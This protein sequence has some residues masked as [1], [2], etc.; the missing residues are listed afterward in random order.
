M[1][2]PVT[3]HLLGSMVPLATLSLSVARWCVCCD[4]VTVQCASIYVLKLLWRILTS[5]KHWDTIVDPQRTRPDNTHCAHD[6]CGIQQQQHEQHPHEPLARHHMASVQLAPPCFSSSSHL[7]TYDAA[8]AMD[9]PAWWPEPEKTLYTLSCA[10]AA[11]LPW[12]AT[13]NVLKTSYSNYRK[14]HT[15]KQRSSKVQN[16]SRGHVMHGAWWCLA[17]VDYKHL[18]SHV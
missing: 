1:W 5:P 4:D 13:S 12:F 15:S 10:D 17:I 9:L 14:A 3:D 6:A 16:A 7:T 2:L 11:L 18:L 8:T